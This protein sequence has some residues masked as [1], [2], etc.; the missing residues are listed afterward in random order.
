MFLVSFIYSFIHFLFVFLINFFYYIIMYVTDYRGAM[1]YCYYNIQYRANVLN[2]QSFHYV[3]LLRSQTF[4]CFFSVSH[5]R[6]MGY[7]RHTQ[8][9]RRRH[10][11][12]L[13]R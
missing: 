8:A 12:L 4:L 1:L 6:L 10:P 9:S 13:M 7:C 11:S 5:Q 3:L 2:H